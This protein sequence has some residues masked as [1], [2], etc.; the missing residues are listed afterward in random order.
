MLELTLFLMTLRSLGT[1]EGFD[2]P[3]GAF[4][5][6]LKLWGTPLLT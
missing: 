3:A 4:K 2:G 1:F 5:I 6:R